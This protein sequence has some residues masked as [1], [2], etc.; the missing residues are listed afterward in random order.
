MIA[1]VRYDGTMSIKNLPPSEILKRTAVLPRD[2]VSL[3]LTARQERLVN[4]DRSLLRPPTAILPRCESILLSFGNVRAIGASDA[5]YVFDA[6]DPAA[7]SFAKE[8]ATIY[9]QSPLL[10]NFYGTME[11]PELIFLEAVLQDTVYSFQRRIRLYEPIV[12]DFLTRV[13]TQVFSDSFVHHQLVPLKDSLQSFELHVKQCYTCLTEVLND[14]ELMLELLLTEQQHA[15]TSGT[16]VPLERHT[17]IELLV[18]GYARQISNISM[19]IGFLLKRL[20]SKQEFV[21][22]ALASQRN[23]YVRINVLIG[24]TGVAVGLATTIAGFYGMNLLSGLE[25]SPL[26]FYYV[27]IGSTLTSAAGAIGCLSFLSGKAMQQRAAASLKDIE[28]LSGALEEMEALDY[29]IKQAMQR[30]RAL[31]KQQF[32]N[33]LLKRRTVSDDEVDLLFSILDVTGDGELSGV[34][35]GPGLLGQAPIS[36]PKTPSATKKEAADAEYVK[37]WWHEELLKTQEAK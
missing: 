31:N 2:L 12:Q 5:V 33:E 7:R 28:T 24:I 6:H 22:L 19:E 21:A 32:K 36:I 3:N 30:N 27:V 37:P 20:Q 17:H 23:R 25:E 4:K 16:P 11:P 14:D 15:K 29:T 35:F 13:E 8:L 26:A 18:G 1:K 9:Q 34:D 10:A